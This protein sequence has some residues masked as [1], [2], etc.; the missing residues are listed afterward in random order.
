MSSATRTF[1]TLI[2]GYAYLEGPR[3][4][5]DRLWVSDFFTKQVIAVG[6]DGT[7]ETV[8]EMDDQPSGLGWLPDG[9]LLVVSMIKRQ[10]LVAADG[11][12]EVHADLSDIA[13]YHLNDMVVDE[14]G[15]AYVS[16]FGSDV[17][18]GEPMTPTRIIRVDPDGSAREVGEPIQF[19][20][21]M[22]ITKDGT[23]A[24]AETLGN[25]ITSFD[26]TKDGDLVNARP[27]ALFGDRPTSAE[28]MEI[29]AQVAYGPDGMTTDA[30]GAIWFADPFNNRAV[31]M[32]DG[33]EVLD[34]ISTADLG[35]GTFAL[36]LGGPDGR[37]LFLCSGTHWP[38][39]EECLADRQARI[40][41]TTV[42]VPRAG[43]P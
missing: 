27:F 30:E 32:R 8:V 26:I 22:V 40:L 3:W 21:G 1:E 17:L 38:H 15:R 35:L 16:G 14:S 10:V 37:T 23:F 18:H 5:D 20:N 19:P 31:R 6:M 4:H 7:T 42:E 36:V 28:M 2:D 9:R 41:T 12:T 24:V 25:R 11:Q 39:E 34:E 43:L 29:V 13:A 33:G